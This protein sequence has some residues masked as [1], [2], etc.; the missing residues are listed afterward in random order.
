MTGESPTTVI[1]S[2]DNDWILVYTRWDEM[3]GDASRQDDLTW[4]VVWWDEII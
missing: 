3:R 2:M 4:G 1:F